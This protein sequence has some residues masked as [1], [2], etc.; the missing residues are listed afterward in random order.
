MPATIRAV[1][2]T[3]GAHAARTGEFGPFRLTEA[4]FAAC[5]VL[6]RHTHDRVTFAV[7]LGGSFSLSIRGQTLDCLAATV[8]TEPVEDAHENRIGTAGASVMVIQP[9][10]TGF[11]KACVRFLDQV[12]HFQ[13]SAIASIG[14]RLA[15]ELRHADDLTALEGQALA[16]EM[17]ALAARLGRTQGHAPPPW[18]TR[19]VDCLHDEFRRG[20]TLDDLAQEAGLHPTHVTRVFRQWY[21]T[22]PGAYMRKLRLEWAAAELVNRETPLSTLALE[23]G[24]ADQAH[25]T[26]AFRRHWGVPPGRYRAE[27]NRS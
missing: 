21:R 18:L 25:F 27:R 16:F 24:F 4:R 13:S 3:M 9:D 15:R 12:N 19:V 7:M 8:L 26:R 5:D 17:L 23:A 2:V 10:P 20:V 6:A 22:S 11:P 1:P 14:M